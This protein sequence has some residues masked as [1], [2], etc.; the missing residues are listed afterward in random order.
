MRAKFLPLLTLI[1]LVVIGFYAW[2][3]LPFYLSKPA[4]P[5]PAGGAKIPEPLPTDP[6]RG[7]A[8]ASKT[9]IEFGDVE[10]S[11]CGQIDPQITSLLAANPDARL[12]WKDC[13]LPSHPNAKA[14][15][16][17]ARCAGDLEKYW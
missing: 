10:C 8:K 6:V 7:N 5:A 14:A 9:I 11:Y 2:R 16:V 12:V 4:A 15:A 1:G 3:V 17:A 13:P